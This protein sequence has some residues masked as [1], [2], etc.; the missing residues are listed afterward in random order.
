MILNILWVICSIPVVTAG[1]STTA[2]Y[3]VTLKLVRD[4]EG[5]TIKSFFKS[6]K[7]N[8]KQSTVIW[9][10]LLAMGSV[11]GVD[12]YFFLAVM[13][14]STKLRTLMIAVFIGF[15]VI[16]AGIML[17]VFPLQC[18]FYNSVK[19]TLLNAFFISIRHFLQTL[20]LLA[21]D[22]GLPVL[23]LT[24]APILQPVFFLFGF[25]MIAF[26]NSYVLVGIFDK[27]MPK[28]EEPE[29]RFGMEDH[30]PDEET[31]T[32]EKRDEETAG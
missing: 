24:V 17:F 1:A 3:Y 19:K 27:Y 15:A 6:F 9:L 4:E 16:Y 14:G 30:W 11:I 13:T 32:A 20:G 7:E 8:F 23:A 21:I 25:P 31:L 22:L 5:P 29:D 26:I 10:I 2:V 12:L 18:R 28:R